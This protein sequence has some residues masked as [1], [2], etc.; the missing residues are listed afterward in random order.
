MDIRQ[1]RNTDTSHLIHLFRTT[2]H[3]VCRQDYD[4]R[5]LLAWAP[6]EIDAEKWTNRFTNSFTIVAHENE[7]ILG[8]AN[9]EN[10]GNVDMFYVH[11][12]WQSKG[13]GSLLFATLEDHAKKLK[14]NRLVS[15]VSITARPFFLRRGFTV[16]R[17][18]VKQVRGAVF[19]N[20]VMFK[21]L[22]N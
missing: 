22:S 17:E 19:K 7:A 1:F 5:Q 4:T 11:A 18:H 9:L 2:V 15:D 12:D 6:T 20:F 21:F 13:I 16:E 14:L 3:T 10:D 8:F